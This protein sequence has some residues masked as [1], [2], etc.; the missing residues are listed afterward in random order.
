MAG[1]AAEFGKVE[2]CFDMQINIVI[3]ADKIAVAAFVQ[4]TTCHGEGM[5]QM[6]V[7]LQDCCLLVQ[8]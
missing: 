8:E 1:C 6:T 7:H 5:E 2:D 4:L 3:S